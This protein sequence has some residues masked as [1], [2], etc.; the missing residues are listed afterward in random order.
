MDQDQLKKIADE[1]LYIYSLVNAND[2]QDKC[3]SERTNQVLDFEKYI[4]HA[5]W[6]VIHKYCSEFQ[7]S[8]MK[9]FR[10]IVSKKTA[11]YLADNIKTLALY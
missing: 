1:L 9:T 6:H 5:D 11:L 7:K 8:D 3:L 2:K 10:K 4:L